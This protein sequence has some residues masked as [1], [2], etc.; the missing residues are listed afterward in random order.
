M[1]YSASLLLT[2]QNDE[3]DSHVPAYFQ[4]ERIRLLEQDQET[5]LPR[6]IST[7]W[8]ERGEKQVTL[9]G[10]DLSLLCKYWFNFEGGQKNIDFEY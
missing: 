7:D 6:I 5:L 3:D 4:E 2:N 8:N 9:L 1:N 10:T